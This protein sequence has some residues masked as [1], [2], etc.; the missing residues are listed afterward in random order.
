MLVLKGIN[1]EQYLGGVLSIARNLYQLTKNVTVI[2][3]I[4]EKKEYK[5]YITK[6]YQKKLKLILFIKKIRQQY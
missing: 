3:M 2:S 5:K 6:D 4:G 1:Q